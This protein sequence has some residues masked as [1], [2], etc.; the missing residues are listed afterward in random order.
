M[1]ADVIPLVV[2]FLIFF[3]SLLS[4]RFGLSVAIIEILLGATGG[5]FG[6]KS[7][8]WMT[9]LAGFGGIVLT[10]LAGTEIDKI[11]RAHV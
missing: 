9:Y 4:L 7:E 2:G 6:L 1:N 8:E 11:G 10:Y 3:S 5:Y